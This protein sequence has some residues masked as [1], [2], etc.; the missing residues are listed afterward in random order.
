M[1]YMVVPSTIKAD[2]LH[3]VQDVIL[4]ALAQAILST[5]FLGM[6]PILH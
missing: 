1:V 3:F 2:V 5:D 6:V 4:R